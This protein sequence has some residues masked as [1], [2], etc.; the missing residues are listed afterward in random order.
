MAFFFPPF[1]PA[2]DQLKRGIRHQRSHR[3]DTLMMEC[4]LHQTPMAKPLW[5]THMSHQAVAKNGFG[6][7]EQDSILVVIHVILLQNAL[8]IIRMVEDDNG[9]VH[10]TELADIPIGS[11]HV[12][13]KL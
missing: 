2:F 10:Q 3:F 6:R 9:Q 4:W 5:S 8:D 7:V 13:K 12:G 11:Y 1:F